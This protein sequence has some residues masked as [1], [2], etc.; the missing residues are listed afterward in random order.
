[1]KRTVIAAALALVAGAAL[2]QTSPP[3]APASAGSVTLSA[4]PPSGSGSVAVT[5]SWSTTAN[6]DGIAA[7]SCQPS[8]QAASVPASGS[9]QLT[10]TSTTNYSITCTW[11]DLS[12]VLAWTPPTTNT[13]GSA[14]GS[15]QVPLTFNLNAGAQGAETP[16]KSGI[17]TNTYTDTVATAQTRCYTV[18]TVD[19]L[20]SASAPTNELCKVLGPAT[21]QASAS[22]TVKVVPNAPTGFTIR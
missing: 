15:T 18:N 1:M 8:W 9:V 10:A 6:D 11:N 14:I 17:T 7:S 21:M 4:S 22:V 13:D 3:T 2:A 19:A 12:A 20:K 16:A 5:L